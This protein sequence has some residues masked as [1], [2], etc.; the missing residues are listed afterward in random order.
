MLFRLPKINKNQLFAPFILSFIL[1]LSFF[2]STREFKDNANIY[3]L[4]IAIAN[5]LLF[6]KAFI[7]T[8][9]NLEDALEK[10]KWFLVGFNLVL[11]SAQF[12]ISWLAINFLVIDSY[13]QVS[14]GLMIIANLGFTLQSFLGQ[15][16][17]IARV[18]LLC[19]A[20]YGLLYGVLYTRF[21]IVPDPQRF[22]GFL[23]ITGY[24]SLI[25]ESTLF[26]LTVRKLVTR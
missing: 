20:V 5:I 8:F 25:L 3:S 17:N 19:I 2:V 12:W 1:V 10:K 13:P 7:I 16:G 24:T 26:F 21:G 22:I 18:S 6:L 4:I 23:Q 11:V 9:G 14:I 15:F